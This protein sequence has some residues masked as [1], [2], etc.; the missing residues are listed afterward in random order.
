MV[1]RPH[2]RPVKAGSLQVGPDVIDSG[3][4]QEIRMCSQGGEPRAY[5]FALTHVGRFTDRH[6]E[7]FAKLKKKIQFTWPEAPGCPDQVCFSSCR[8]PCWFP[9]GQVRKTGSSRAGLWCPRGHRKAKGAASVLRLERRD[10][11]PERELG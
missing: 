4:H 6:Q 2:P 7:F 10:F 9:L 1:P 5:I 11:K 3:V 8:R